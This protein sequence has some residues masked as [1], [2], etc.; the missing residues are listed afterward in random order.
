MLDSGQQPGSVLIIKLTAANP[1]L[2]KGIERPPRG[3]P[4]TLAKL[5][6][7][8]GVRNYRNRRARSGVAERERQ[9]WVLS[10]NYRRCR[11]REAETAAVK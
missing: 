5:S 8:R 7:A 6:A 2:C 4:C 9:W 1:L 3:A 11:L 10:L